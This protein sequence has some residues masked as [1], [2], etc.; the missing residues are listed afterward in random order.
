MIS[1][2][3]RERLPFLVA[4]SFFYTLS[5]FF[6]ADLSLLLNKPIKLKYTFVYNNNISVQ[7]ILAY[8]LK[9]LEK[10]YL[11]R[12]FIPKLL[13]KFE[14]R[15]PFYDKR[16]RFIPRRIGSFGVN[17]IGLMVRCSGRFSRAQASKFH[18][19]PERRDAFE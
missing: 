16:N 10:L 1:S 5:K 19:F 11:P 12:E 6:K 17:N 4:P 18:Y 7:V 13:N 14:G 3:F 9:K 15:K 8:I 2:S